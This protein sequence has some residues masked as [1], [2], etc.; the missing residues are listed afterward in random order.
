MFLNPTPR[1]WQGFSEVRP[2]YVAFCDPRGQVLWQTSRRQALN[3]YDTALD[4][5]VSATPSRVFARM[6]VLHITDS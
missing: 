3:G 2:L 5:Q 4:V 6:N 1:L